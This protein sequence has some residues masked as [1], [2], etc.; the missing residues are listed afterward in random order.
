[1]KKYKH[2]F[3]DLDRTLWNFEKNA[4]EAFISIIEK[5]NLSGYFPDVDFFVEEY[6]E[7]NEAMWVQY[8]NGEIKKDFLRVERFRLLLKSF[9]I[10]DDA[11]SEKISE[12]F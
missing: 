5:Y 1:M 3:F 10:V 11:L 6:H 7:I 8:R 9:G 2:L 4:R 12:T